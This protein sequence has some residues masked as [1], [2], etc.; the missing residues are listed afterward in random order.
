MSNAVFS[1]RGVHKSFFGVPVLKNIDFDAFPGEVH[2]LLG[3]NGAGKST[4]MKIMAGVYTM[5]SGAL[6]LEGKAVQ[7]PTP[8][9]A[10][11]GGVVTIHQELNM[12]T[13]LTVL[14]NLFLARE[15]KTS[16]GFLDRA[17]MK[18][19]AQSWLKI[20]GLDSLVERQVKSLPISQQQVIE[21]ARAV[22]MS[23]R[24]LIMDEPTSSL[25]DRE[26][27]ELF[28]IIKDLK[29]TGISIIYISHR[30]EELEH[31]A[32][33]V[34]VLRD[35][36]FV[37]SKPYKETNLDEIISAMAGRDI[38]EK[39]PRVLCPVGKT[40]LS[41]KNLTCEPYFRKV[42]FDVKEGE[43]IGFAGLVGAGRTKI[44]KT[45]GGVFMP[46][47]GSITLDGKELHNKSVAEAVASKIAYVSEDR[48]Q[49]GLAVRMTIL[50]NCALPNMKLFSTP[51]SIDFNRA[52]KETLKLKDDLRIK[53]RSPY[54][55]LQYL[56]GGNQQ[57]IMIGKWMISQPRVFFFDEPTR[58]VDV[59]AKINIYSIINQMKVNK[60]GVAV[61]SSE[62][63]EL[64]GICD[65]IF[66]VSN[67]NITAEL[68]PS[69]T[70]QEEI[71][72]Y[73][74]INHQKTEVTL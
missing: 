48:K 37:M 43:I 3:E 34:T 73:A 29:S 57:K 74:A 30:L 42:S 18:E 63:P 44:A 17:R 65:R 47:S 27:V 58:G 6:S 64:L 53:M 7:F 21:I 11:A 32:D 26:T 55:R 15:Y 60:I 70:S 28:R 72:R 14:E 46:Q 59:N 39:Y 35:G 62:L 71:L 25:S 5:D 54:D 45:L 2:A 52:A 56:S 36:N 68:V 22:S 67:G 23:S 49:E 1:A 9:D 38:T 51:F 8:A 31:I 66:V 12:C 20:F 33:R 19:M 10:I 24:V 41:V 40:I 16:W 69:Q 50:E 13:H 4:L 61:I